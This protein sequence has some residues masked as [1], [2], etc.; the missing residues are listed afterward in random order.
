LQLPFNHIEATASN[1]RK[2]FYVIVGKLGARIFFCKVSAYYQG[3]YR[4]ID[5][6]FLDLGE[7]VLYFEDIFSGTIPSTCGLISAMW[8]LNSAI[9]G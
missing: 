9:S 2:I 5:T 4:D 3:R 1:V 7:S 8:R 6:G